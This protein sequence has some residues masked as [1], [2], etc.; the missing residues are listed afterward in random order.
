LEKKKAHMH[1][2]TIKGVTMDS[3][4]FPVIGTI[5]KGFETYKGN[6]SLFIGSS[7][8][9]ISIVAFAWALDRILNIQVLFF[10]AITFVTLG[11]I[12]VSIRTLKGENTGFSDFFGVYRL[13][14]I[15]LI[16]SFVSYFAVGTAATFFIIMLFVVGNMDQALYVKIFA[17]ALATIPLL[18]PALYLGARIQFYGFIM[19]ETNSATGNMT[20]ESLE[21]S[22]II[23]KGKAF[24]IFL[25]DLAVVGML[26][27][28]TALLGVGL[29][30][31]IPV[32]VLAMMHTYDA[33]R[34]DLQL[35]APEE[36]Y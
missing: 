29:L 31:A 3:N 11:L 2:A 30:I 25:L 4:Q 15:F 28:G 19:V 22:W 1:S 21:K 17:I 32:S 27:L 35:Q 24:D 16:S 23:T 6:L 5:R 10:I 20:Y 26:V 33:L 34:G 7:M 13:Y 36:E 14:P 18:M 9:S 12:T 8:L